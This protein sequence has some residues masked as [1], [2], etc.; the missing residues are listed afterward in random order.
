M[1][2]AE[3]VREAER[4]YTEIGGRFVCLD[5]FGWPVETFRG[6]GKWLVNAIR[7]LLHTRRIV[8]GPLRYYVTS[9]PSVGCDNGRTRT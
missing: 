2:H 8:R 6:R 5:R 3:K 7:L 9:D 4:A 1:T